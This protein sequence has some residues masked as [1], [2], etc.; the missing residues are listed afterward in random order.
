MKY[1]ILTP[2]IYLG[3]GGCKIQETGTIY[4]HISTAGLIKVNIWN[5][6]VFSKEGNDS[7]LMNRAMCISITEVKSLGK[8]LQQVRGKWERKR[9]IILY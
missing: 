5:A 8:F 4:D 2:V 9:T 1:Q 7:V 6:Q 3:G